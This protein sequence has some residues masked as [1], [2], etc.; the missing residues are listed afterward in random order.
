VHLKHGR[1]EG[2]MQQPGRLSRDLLQQT[3]AR[4]LRAAVEDGWRELAR[5]WVMER[6]SK[7]RECSYGEA[8]GKVSAE[9]CCSADGKGNSTAQ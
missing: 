4:A 9:E 2:A 6:E 5:L 1:R 8:D 7:C 3:M